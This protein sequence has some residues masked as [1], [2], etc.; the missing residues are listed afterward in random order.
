VTLTYIYDDSILHFSNVLGIWCY[1]TTYLYETIA[2]DLLTFIFIVV[3]ADRRL[4]RHIT[5]RVLHQLLDRKNNSLLFETNI[6][7]EHA[8][9]YT[10]RR[11]L[12]ILYFSIIL[13][14][15]SLFL[16]PLP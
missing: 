4:I 12:G 2:S 16:V 8:S 5:E 3:A 9:R 14:R 6:F 15:N 13:C 7:T 10:S 11:A 1:D